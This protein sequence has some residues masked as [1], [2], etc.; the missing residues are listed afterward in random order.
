MLRTIKTFLQV[1]PAVYNASPAYPL[2]PSPEPSNGHNTSTEMP[3]D[4]ELNGLHINGSPV[5]SPSAS[6]E[7]SKEAILFDPWCDPKN[8]RQIQFQDIS[9]AAFK[10]KS[11]I[12]MVK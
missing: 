1:E 4:V 11:G 2:I 7:L 8:P 5:A 12:M 6:G 3:I 9:A 10:I